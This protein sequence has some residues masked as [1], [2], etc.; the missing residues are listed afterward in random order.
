VRSQATEFHI[1]RTLEK[2]ISSITY[3]RYAIITSK[4]TIITI[5]ITNT[6][7]APSPALP[8]P[9]HQRPVSNLERERTTSSKRITNW[10]AVRCRH[11]NSNPQE[12]S[13]FYI[14]IDTSL[15]PSIATT[16]AFALR[17]SPVTLL[18]RICENLHG[19]YD[20]CK[21]TDD[22]VCT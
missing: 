10:E 11:S 8:P 15:T 3:F 20:D 16:T 5:T 7:T 19:W 1:L 22:E 21:R 9:H 12:R 18:A 13:L 17:D 4:H 14:Q 2:R 6:N